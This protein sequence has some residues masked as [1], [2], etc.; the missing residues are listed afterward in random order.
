MSAP[1]DIETGT[2]LWFV[3][4]NTRRGGDPRELTVAKVGRVWLTTEDPLRRVTRVHGESLL[5]DGGGY[6]S[7]GRCYRSREDYEAWLET[8]RTWCDL[9]HK[10]DRKLSMP[11]G[12]SAQRVRLALG[13]LRMGGDTDPLQAVRALVDKLPTDRGLETY[14][15]R[16]ELA[17]V[18]RL[19]A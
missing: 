7:P 15:A 5:A 3:P 1:L 13:L 2:K 11:E 8:W 16:E 10:V 9:R 17:V 6:T 18:R 14:H 12:L 19:F 4:E